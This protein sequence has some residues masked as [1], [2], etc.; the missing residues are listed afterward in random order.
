MKV[1]GF[2]G[3]KQ[4]G[5]DTAA[6][7]LSRILLPQHS[8]QIN[9][10][11]ALKDEVCM[12]CKITRQF[13]DEHKDNFR[14]I[15]QGYGTDF[16][17][18]LHGEQYWILKWLERVNKLAPVPAYL[19]CTDVRFINEAAVVRRLGGTLIRVER[20]GVFSDGHAS[21][22]EQ[23]ELHAD[24]TVHNDGTVEDL[25]AKLKNLKLQ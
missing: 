6:R 9:F 2:T 24:F 17:R 13:L 4:S 15:M 3:Y 7:E 10:A 12:A 1:I 8:V 22:T 11:D 23:R 21:E 14:L 16:R 20:P 25:K 19:L 18:K 5:K